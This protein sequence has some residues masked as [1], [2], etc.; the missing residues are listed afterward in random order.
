[1]MAHVS[2]PPPPPSRFRSDVPEALD[3][4]VL[5]ALAKD[6]ARRPPSCAIFRERLDEALAAF[7][8]AELPPGSLP[9]VVRGAETADLVLVPAGPFLYGPK[10]REV[11]LDAFYIDRTPVTNAEFASF[12]RATR[13][14]PSDEGSGR[15][16][17]HFRSGRAPVGAEHHPVTHVSWTD[18][19]AYAAW[20]GKRLPTEAEW[21]K[22][23]RGTD[24]R[25]YP[26][27][28]TEPTA[29]HANY[30]KIKG[31]T[32]SV[33]AHAAGASPYGVLDLAGNVWEWCED[34]DDPDFYLDGPTRN[35]R[36]AR[37]S[38]VPPRMARHVVRGG[39]WLYGPRA[40]R[41]VYR[42]SFEAH[43]RVASGGFRC[44]RS[45]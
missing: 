1:M 28:R 39:S 3:R 20:A 9:S 25:R 32:T 22:A 23:A 35:P 2:E 41:T 13:Y 10:R 11:D 37:P 8:P 29:E 27:G 14:A 12:V 18:A 44:A 26:W 36:S 19:R 4:L 21:E 5:D 38:T 43:Y 16:L 45:A 31:G 30:G 33:D 6:P 40:L 42:A 7:E 24:G 34:V 17:H 15:F